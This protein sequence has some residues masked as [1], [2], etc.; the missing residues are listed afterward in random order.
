MTRP[1]DPFFDQRIA[2]W[3]ETD[4]TRAPDQVLEV[5]LAALPAISRRRTVSP[6][7]RFLAMPMSM[8]LAVAAAVAIAVL[9][10]GGAVYLNL[11]AVGGPSPTV[12][13]V[14]SASVV[15]HVTVAP[16]PAPAVFAYAK[17]TGYHEARIWVANLDGTGAHELLPQQA[18]NQQSPVWSADGTRLLYSQNPVAVDAGG[19]P[20]EAFRFYLT[21]ASGSD[22]QL[23]DAGCVA[24]C[25]GDSNAAFSRDGTHL[26]FVRT[27][28]TPPDPAATE[29]TDHKLPGPG[30]RSVL[31]TL[32]LVTGQV[33]ELA[34]TAI[35]GFSN[36][37][38]SWSP[39]GARIVFSQDNPDM[40]KGPL[41][42]GDFAPTDGPSLFVVDADGGNLHRIAPT[43]WPGAWSPD[44]TRIAFQLV[45]YHDIVIT[46]G[47]GNGYTYASSSD[48]FTIRPD[49]TDLR[50]LT[51]DGGSRAPH[52][53]ADGRIWFGLWFGNV[54]TQQP[55][56]MDADGSNQRQLSFPSSLLAAGGV[57]NQPA[58][59]VLTQP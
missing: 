11:P 59:A 46:P 39:D 43:G 17:A 55:R 16:S 4:P 20:I 34:S 44:G 56:S 3:L 23:V 25:L 49:G 50:Q 22:P 30:E 58:L 18:G 35:D 28:Q 6:P 2:D 47:K 48:I 52:W 57:P 53:T 42:N 27:I 26:V 14:A 37:D 10:F 31:A 1:N 51:S 41:I 12:G 9:G 38:P 13:A 40:Y 15:P 19:F 32:D 45:T 7:R 54:A 5:V 36:R 8:R 29:S 33:V 24:P 21:D